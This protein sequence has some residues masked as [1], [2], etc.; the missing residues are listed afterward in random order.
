[1]LSEAEAQ[2]FREAID[3]YDMDTS[4]MFGASDFYQVLGLDTY[5]E[6]SEVKYGERNQYLNT[7]YANG[8]EQDQGKGCLNK[9]KTV[10]KNKDKKKAYDEGLRK[11]LS[12]SASANPAVDQ[13]IRSLESERNQLRQKNQRLETEASQ[14]RFLSGGQG[15]SVNTLQS[16][17]TSL[18]GDI[19]Q[20]KHANKQKDH[21]LSRMQETVSSSQ[22]EVRRLQQL[23]N[24]NQQTITVLR[25]ASSFRSGI[26]ATAGKLFR[27]MLLLGIGWTLY[28]IFWSRESAKPLLTDSAHEWVTSE[29]V[30]VYRKPDLKS[31]I[32]GELPAGT[33]LQAVSKTTYFIRVQP[34]ED[35]DI[36]DGYVLKSVLKSAPKAVTRDKTDSLP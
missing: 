5:S 6:Y 4:S 27:L 22:S 28:K 31:R 25:N 33:P 2:R 23:N 9:A 30:N 1:M 29:S 19:E 15:Q 16:T 35:N 14:L 8:K 36:P 13:K 18:H 3:D 10:L 34:E 20:L 12:K 32:V 7:E 26:R 21:A 17:V 24:Q 11:K